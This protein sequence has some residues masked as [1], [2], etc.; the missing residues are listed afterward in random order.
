MSKDF[1]GNQRKMSHYY[2]GPKS[3]EKWLNLSVIRLPGSILRIQPNLKVIWDKM[4]NEWN[5]Q[6]LLEMSHLRLI[7]A[8][9]TDIPHTLIDDVDTEKMLILQFTFY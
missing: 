9:Y 2:K 7:V 5:F 3:V 4:E 1:P 6:L 8:D